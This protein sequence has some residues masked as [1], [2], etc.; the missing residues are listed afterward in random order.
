MIEHVSGCE[1]NRL[2]GLLGGRLAGDDVAALEEH[3]SACPHCRETLEA[4]AS[5]RSWWDHLACLDPREVE[6]VGENATEEGLP[7]A[8]LEPSDLVGSLGRLGPYE[9]HSVI[10]QGGMGMV[11]KGFDPALNRP[12]AIKVISPLVATNAAARRRF[13]REARAA[14]AVSHDHIIA[15][16]AVA[17]SA[18]GLP[19]LVMPLVSG[20]SLQ[21]RLDRDGPLDVAEILRI[22]MQTAAGLAAAHAQGL[23]HRDVKP[24]NLLLENG[25][26]RVKIT[27]FGLARAADDASLSHSVVIAGTPQY[28]APE[29]A[30]GGPIDHRSDLF[31]LGTVLYAAATGHSPFRASTT[32][33]VLKR[34]C[35]DRPRAVREINPSVPGWLEAIIDRLLEKDPD[36]RFQSAAEVADLL[37]QGMAHLEFPNMEP[38]PQSAKRLAAAGRSRH[39]PRLVVMTLVLILGLSAF[40]AAGAGGIPTVLNLFAT[41]LR[42]RTPEGTLVVEVDDP[43]IKLQIDNDDLVI[44]GAGPQEIRLAVGKH[45]LSA[46]K[47]GKRV[48][49]ELVTIS[50]D[51]KKTVVVR[52]EP[53]EPTPEPERIAT[54]NPLA[55]YPA[56]VPPSFPGL[57]QE[58]PRVEP[59]EPPAVPE[60]TKSVILEPFGGQP[61]WFALFSRDGET[62]SASTNWSGNIKVYDVETQ[63]QVGRMNGE[64]NTAGSCAAFSPDG[65]LLAT[66]GAYQILIWD[67]SKHQL[68]TRFQAHTKSV[69]SLQ[70]SPDGKCLVSAGDDGTAKFWEVGSWKQRNWDA[71]TPQERPAM[72]T[73]TDP[74]FAAAFSPN[75]KTLALASGDYR[76]ERPPVVT[77][78]DYD[79]SSGSVKLRLKLA[80]G[81]RGPAWSVAFSPDGNTL[82]SCSFDSVIRLW[83][84]SS[85]RQLGFL[86]LQGKKSGARGLSFSPDGRTLAAGL[87]DS[88]IGVWDVVSRRKTLSLKGHKDH[89]FTVEFSPDGK[90]LAS[91]SKDGTVRLWELSENRP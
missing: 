86:P 56:A 78:Y 84:V 26:E 29:Q 20:R 43:K 79:A 54:S 30:S 64:A 53:N 87:F 38:P 72:L 21:E 82:A 73:S 90:T 8:F 4:L 33:A 65:N 15:I 39:R 55:P 18:T 91:A 1:V 49:E 31:S 12:V 44:R 11:L 74:Y 27:D 16:H 70:F 60:L 34:V 62:L 19:Y 85:G 57:E 37:R 14:A 17:E 25:V 75:G 13:A 77:L 76:K 47:D 63:Q 59:D 9:V 42:I 61:C 67:F 88:S 5:D 51:Q 83:D 45:R 52:L 24:A 81:N 71:G 10:G 40:G 35:E 50:R 89:A 48:R 41:I 46:S 2:K 28:M 6:R 7:L 32:M 66:S 58:P 69:R 22:G 80:V 36:R 68:L 3:L 23:V